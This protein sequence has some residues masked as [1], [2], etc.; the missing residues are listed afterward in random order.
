MLRGSRPRVPFR[1]LREPST[2]LTGAVA[3]SSCPS[4]TPALVDP[5]RSFTLLTLGEVLVNKHSP[6]PSIPRVSLTSPARHSRAT[7]QQLPEPLTPLT[8]GTVTRSCLN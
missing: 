7:S 8:T 6:L 4:S 3:T 1:R 5:V 2:P